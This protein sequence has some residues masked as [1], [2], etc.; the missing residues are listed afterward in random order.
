MAHTGPGLMGGSR[1]RGVDTNLR[2]HGRSRSR[3]R[4][5]S[6]DHGV[7]NRRSS[8]RS[9]SIGH[10]LGQLNGDRKDSGEQLL[11]LQKHIAMR[12]EQL[13]LLQKHIAMR[14]EKL[15]L[16]QKHIAMRLE[17]GHDA[18]SHFNLTQ[19]RR[20]AERKW[21]VRR[22]EEERGCEGRSGSERKR[23]SICI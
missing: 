12:L 4:G 17:I 2:L 14:L 8:S 1:D 22:K 5:G 10:G 15:L 6:V 13:L 19:V 21:D 20:C 3:A 11:L 23:Y 16:L 7:L 9:G 18:K